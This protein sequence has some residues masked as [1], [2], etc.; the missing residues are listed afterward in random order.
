LTKSAIF[1][2]SHQENE[3]DA[4]MLPSSRLNGILTL[5]PP[6][7]MGHIYQVTEAPR[8]KAGL[9]AFRYLKHGTPESYVY[10]VSAAENK[11]KKNSIFKPALGQKRSQKS[12]IN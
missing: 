4:V 7:Y 3:N 5:K 6:R 12:L 8:R 10:K 9:A 11:S 1:S 2:A